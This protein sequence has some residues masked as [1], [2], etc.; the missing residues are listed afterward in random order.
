MNV[1]DLWLQLRPMFEGDT[2]DYPEIDIIDLNLEQLDA[3]ITYLLENSRE[4]SF[5]FRLRENNRMLVVAPS[6]QV[7]IDALQKE[8]IVGAMMFTFPPMP[9]IVVYAQRKDTLTISYGRDDWDAMKV[10]ML[11]DLLSRLLSMS[12]GARIVPDDVNFTFKERDLFMKMWQ[13]YH[14]ELA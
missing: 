10:L 9:T 2:D 6:P 1:T 4:C 5:Q 3:C 12:A 13:A 11:F 14:Y 8:E 7:M